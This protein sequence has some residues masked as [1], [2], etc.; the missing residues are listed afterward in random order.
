MRVDLSLGMHWQLA[1]SSV[2][3]YQVTVAIGH[4]KGLH[5]A[6]IRVA[7]CRSHEQPEMVGRSSSPTTSPSV[8]ISNE[9][10]TPKHEV[11]GQAET[12][13]GQVL[14][15]ESVRTSLQGAPIRPSAT[16]ASRRSCRIGAMSLVSGPE[17]PMRGRPRS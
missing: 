8:T 7:G 5:V 12:A 6:R 11:A 9:D 17:E 15:D 1:C 13:S 4:E 3:R 10:V 16:K 14:V 2:C